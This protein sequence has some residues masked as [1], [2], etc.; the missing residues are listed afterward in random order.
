M[1]T[2]QHIR[3]YV[4]TFL[5]NCGLFIEQFNQC[6]GLQCFMDEFF[7]YFTPY[8]VDLAFFIT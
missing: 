4:I 3:D 6:S 5:E 7:I 8:L 2:I 1:N